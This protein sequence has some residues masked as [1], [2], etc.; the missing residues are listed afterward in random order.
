M[1]E[2]RYGQAINRAIADAMAGD[3]SVVLFG[4]DVAAPGGPFGV[5][6]G[7]RDKF[8]EDRVRDAPISEAALVG[9][10]V[11]AAMSGLRPIVEIMFMDFI[12]LGMDALVNQAA[13]AR[14][15]FG[16]QCALPLVVRLP[17][18]G[19]ISA[20]PQHSQCLEAW[21]AHIPGLKVVC[22]ATIPDAYGLTLAAIRDPDPV[23]V[24]ENKS[25]YAMKGD[26]PEAPQAVPIGKAATARDGR[27]LTI[28]TYGAMRAT[29]L[30]AAATLANDGIE[31]EIIDLRSLQPWDEAAV[32]ASLS[33]THRLVVLHEAT[34]A[35]GI[36]AEIAAR[37][38]DVG[39][40]EL[41]GPIVRV[42]A[43]F[44]PVPFA[45]E[46]ERAWRPDAQRVVAAARRVL[47]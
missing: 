23:I 17:H 13:K 38:S 25:L 22:P 4:E 18:G 42:G 16:G 2:V 33:R 39:F 27:D 35:F 46:L 41:D 30:E 40:D 31:A 43:P 5:T 37:M 8:G 26:L 14:F 47:A 28:V 15:M 34:E 9:A 10:G 44:V 24:V 12:T 21:L 7:L 45:K 6:R 20:G 1:S 32:L 3:P 19:G 29:A 11:G 36:G